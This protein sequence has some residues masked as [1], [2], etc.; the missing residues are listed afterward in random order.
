[1]LDLDDRNMLLDGTIA[2]IGVKRLITRRSR[3]LDLQGGEEVVR[4]I[5]IK[6]SHIDLHVTRAYAVRLRLLCPRA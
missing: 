1:M 6:R 2:R 5:F 4:V 3:S